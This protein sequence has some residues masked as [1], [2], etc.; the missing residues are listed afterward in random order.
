MAPKDQRTKRHDKG[1]HDTV[2]K[3]NFMEGFNDIEIW[4]RLEVVIEKMLSQ[5]VI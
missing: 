3:W 2:P 5:R 4:G 1:E